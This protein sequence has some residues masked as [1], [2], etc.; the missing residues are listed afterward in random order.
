[1]K[2]RI[3]LLFVSVIFLSCS[4]NPDYIQNLNTAKKTFELFES[5][6][7]EEQMSYFADDLIYSPPS[8]GMKS[9]NK[10]EF[11]KLLTMYQQSFDNLSY[12]ADVWLPGTDDDGNLDG[13]VRTYGTWNSTDS[14][15]GK[16]TK[17]LQSYHFFNFNKEGKIIAQ[18]DFFDATGLMNSINIKNT[19]PVDNED[20]A[21]ITFVLE[22][23]TKKNSK[24]SVEKFTRYL[25][26]YVEAR[27]PSIVYGYYISD[28]GKK[29]TLI[30]R[31]KNSQDALQHGIDF[32]NGPNFENFFKFFEIE[33]F[34]T[35][36]NAT[37]E[38]KTFAKE[39][40]FVIEYR[41]PV[42]G[43]VRR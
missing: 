24:A 22:L 3:F 7:L 39:N 31:Y 29:I 18:G 1:M 14:S 37:D 10:V 28:D 2:K 9:M 21:E 11:K 25:S 41:T 19:I 33:H 34:I 42:G 30:E 32:I 26:E 6:S 38:F 15:T 23:S 43:Y 13:S 5:E 35:I 40:G 36:G 12:T 17:P 4:S 8:Y 27:E 20:S 16:N